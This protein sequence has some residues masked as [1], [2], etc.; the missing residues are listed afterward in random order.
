MALD[1][2]QMFLPP[3]KVNVINQDM[4]LDSPHP[5]DEIKLIEARIARMEPGDEDV[6]VL[7]GR[8]RKLLT[9]ASIN[10]LKQ[11]IAEL[12]SRGSDFPGPEVGIEKGE[13]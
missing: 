10:R 8:R 9:E 2:M 6:K 13:M 7:M 1:W 4:P 12:E 11:D 5:E 3:D